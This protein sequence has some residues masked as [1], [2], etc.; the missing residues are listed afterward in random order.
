M[1]NSNLCLDVKKILLGEPEVTRSIY[2][3]TLWQSALVAL[4]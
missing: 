1:D 4:V 2:G 3:R